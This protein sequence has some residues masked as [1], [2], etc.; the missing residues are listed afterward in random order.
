MLSLENSVPLSFDIDLQV[1]DSNLNPD[2][3]ITVKVESG[4][5][6][7]GGS[8]DSPSVTDAVVSISAPNG[9]EL[10]ALRLKLKASVSPEYAGTCLNEKQTLTIKNLAINLPD[11]IEI[12]SN[13]EE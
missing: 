13:S 1:L 7:H 5:T 8:L 4:S 12:T 9:L 3:D 6:I 11:G 10:S 2:P